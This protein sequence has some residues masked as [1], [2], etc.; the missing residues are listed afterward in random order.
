MSRQISSLN[1][2][3]NETG[4]LMKQLAREASSSA[5]RQRLKKIAGEYSRL[6]DR[7]EQMDRKMIAKSTQRIHDLH[8]QDHEPEGSL[9]EE[10]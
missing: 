4:D 3:I 9:L 6:L 5:E 1:V 2:D 10:Q 7:I 8:D